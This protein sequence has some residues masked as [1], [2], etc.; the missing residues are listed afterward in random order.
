MS[1]SVGASQR[2]LRDMVDFTF[3]KMGRD[4]ATDRACLC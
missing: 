3:Q 2:L 4:R 1:K